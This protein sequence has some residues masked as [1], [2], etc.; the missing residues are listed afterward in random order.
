MTDIL[1]LSSWQ[2]LESRQDG[3]EY[4]ITA[5]HTMQPEACTRS[6]KEGPAWPVF[7]SADGADAALVALVVVVLVAIVEVLIPGVG[8]VAGVLRR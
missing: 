8:G 3:G 4:I 1:D 6:E 5:K 2:V 7:E